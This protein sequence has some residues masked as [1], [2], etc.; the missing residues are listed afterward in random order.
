MIRK[1]HIAGW[2]RRYQAAL[3]H[4]LGQGADASVKPA[5]VLGRQAA[6][7]GLETL[8]LARIHTTALLS[9]ASTGGSSAPGPRMIGR[10]RRFYSEAIVPIEKTHQAARETKVQVDHLN[11]VLRRRTAESSASSRHL[12]RG[13]ARRRTAESALKKSENHQAVMLRESRQLQ[14]RLRLQ[15]REILSLQETERQQFSRQLHD[16]IA[17]TLLGINVWLVTLKTLDKANSESLKKEIVN[18]QRLVKQFITKVKQFAH[19]FVIQH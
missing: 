18:T 4:Y 16:E 13:I 9:W 6:G 7:L 1:T 17:Q 10:A 15:T 5:L 2:S 19:E 12:V 3:S 8:D 14:Q 11:Q